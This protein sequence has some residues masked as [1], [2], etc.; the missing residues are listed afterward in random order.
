MTIQPFT[1]DNVTI[2]SIDR[3]SSAL[4]G[5]AYDTHHVSKLSEHGRLSPEQAADWLNSIMDRITKTIQQ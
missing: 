5:A 1:A 4:L 2:S 3:L